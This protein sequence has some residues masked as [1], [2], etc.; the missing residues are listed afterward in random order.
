VPRPPPYAT[1]TSH[2]APEVQGLLIDL[3][4]SS[5]DPTPPVDSGAPME[6]AQHL[7]RMNQEER[8]QV[9]DELQKEDGE[10]FL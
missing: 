10:D 2:T 7:Q 3:R 5:E 9:W 4:P 6:V 8:E 1:T